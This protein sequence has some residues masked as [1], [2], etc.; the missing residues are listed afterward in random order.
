MIPVQRTQSLHS[1]WSDSNSLGATIPLHT[2]AKPLSRFLHRRQVLGILT[3]QRSSPLSAHNLD[4]LMCYLE[5]KEISTSTKLLILQ[6]LDARSKSEVEAQTLARENALP[7]LIRLLDSAETRIVAS[8]RTLL[9]NL[10]RWNSVKAEIALLYPVEDFR[11]LPTFLPL[12]TPRKQREKEKEDEGLP[13]LRVSLKASPSV[14]TRSISSR[15]VHIRHNGRTF[16]SP[17]AMSPLPLGPDERPMEIDTNL[18]EMDGIVDHTNL[19]YGGSDPSS[20]SSDMSHS[21]SG[22]SYSQV[23]PLINFG[24]PPGSG[25]Q[26]Q[27]LL[28][29]RRTTTIKADSTRTN[30]DVPESWAVNLRDSE[31]SDEESSS[32]DDDGGAGA[33]PSTTTKFPRWKIRIH[34][35]DNNGHILHVSINETVADLTP[36]LNLKLPAREERETHELYLK[37]WGRERILSQHER[38]ANILQRQLHQAGYD[39]TDGHDLLSGAVIPFP[40][41]FVYRSQ[42]YGSAG[43]QLSFTHFEHIDLTGR[44]LSTI[45]VALHQHADSI[46]SLRLSRNPM[47]DIPRDFVKSC[48]ALSQLYLSHMSMK[49]VPLNIRHSATLTLLDLSSNRIVALDDAYLEDLSHLTTLH[50]QNNRLQTLPRTFARLQGLADLNISNN[51]FHVF[52]VSVTELSSLCYL[53]ISFNSISVLPYEIG[54]LKNLER[55]VIV[56]NQISTL[57]EEFSHLTRLRELD[58]RRN[59]IADLGATCMLPAL[60]TLT[61]DHN[62]LQNVTTSLGPCLTALDV[63]YNDITALSVRGVLSR[64]DPAILASLDISSAKISV[65]DDDTLAPLVSLRVLKLDRNS[66]RTIP[67]SLGDLKSLEMLS[68]MDNS[69]GELPR[70]IGKLQK[71]ECLDVQRNRLT[72]LPVSLWNCAS[73]SRLNVTSNLLVRWHAPPIPTVP[74]DK[75]LPAGLSR[76]PSVP[77]IHDIPPLAYSLQMLYLGENSLNSLTYGILHPLMILRELRVLNLSFNNID[78]IPSRFFCRLTKLEEVYLSGNRLTH[79]PSEDLCRLTRLS[80]LFLNGNRLQN[81]PHE[82]GKVQSLTVLDVGHNMLKYN[83][84]NIDYDWNWNFNKSLVYLNLSGNKQ[85]Q[86][87]SDVA[88]DGRR[89]GTS[90]IDWRLLSGFSELSQ[91]RV[92]GLMDVTIPITGI[93]SS[94]DIPDE[95]ENRRVR[96]SSSLV[97]GLSYGIADT[98]GRKHYPHMM[99][100]VHAFHGMNKDTVFAMFGR[101]Q[102]VNQTVGTCNSLAKFL[103]DNFI[104]VFISQLN[105]LDPQRADGVTDALRRSFLKLN[106]DF[107]NELFG[108]ARERMSLAGEPVS[109]DPFS[110]AS[111]IVVYIVGKKIYVANVGNTL[112]IISSGGIAHPVSR[113]HEPCDPAETIRIRAAE[114]WIS[115]SSPVNDGLDISRSFGFYHLMPMINARPDVCEYERT[116]LD[117]S[118]IIANRGLWDYVD[119]QT[120]V[121]IVGRMEPAAAAQKLRDLAI[122]Y[123]SKGSIM[124]MVVRLTDPL[125]DET[126]VPSVNR[127]SGSFDVG[128]SAAALLPNPVMNQG[129]A[130]VDEVGVLLESA[131]LVNEDSDER[132]NTIQQPD[133]V[134]AHPT[135]TITPTKDALVA[136]LR[137][138]D[139]QT[140]EEVLSMLHSA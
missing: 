58:C 91:L 35:P 88:N 16:E 14:P 112:A 86:I 24:S 134:I 42:F 52:P 3:Q 50:I 98:L 125:D 131:E 127:H 76:R 103:K 72:E 133:P 101:S 111:G 90:L 70:S 84:N 8:V 92:L 21:E 137:N 67:E 120:A 48:T 78:E 62:D 1:W 110:G 55:L 94:S 73:L 25:I 4:I 10:S 41:K 77:G 13:S 11:P 34:G 71:L 36:R 18:E 74:Q 82:L 129:A 23:E 28:P 118:I 59:R 20:P 65:L 115:P 33:Q 30:F 26:L 54:H 109:T 15:K 87:K 32:D 124:T 5:F 60:E 17:L 132:A 130:I 122:S 121:N 96:T 99:D 114:G 45:P 128:G 97:N 80:T 9:G 44:S 79:I 107:H 38:P 123:G 106:Q 89:L 39:E 40:L 31:E 64:T 51:D 66:L 102:S 126:I 29:T 47:V 37:E 56:G 108:P 46:V 104:R 136:A 2:L 49:K 75:A 135:S 105:C 93:H 95:S 53:D 83:I 12:L 68:C 6:D 57:P 138:L 19:H 140:L 116:D 81:I 63:S 100:L 117:D 7:V 27:S 69:L 43:E 139:E 22:H 61:A 85:L 113:K 119:Y